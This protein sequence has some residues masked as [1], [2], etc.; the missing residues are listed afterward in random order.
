MR[1]REFEIE[2]GTLRYWVSEND[3]E[4]RSLSSCPALPLTIACLISNLITLPSGQGAWCGIPLLM[5]NRGLSRSTGA[6]TTLP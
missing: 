3:E 5:G 1:K 4:R 6:W 2:R